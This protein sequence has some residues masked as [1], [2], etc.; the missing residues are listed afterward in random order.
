MCVV[1]VCFDVR[2]V[3]GCF[4]VVV[5]VL[6]CGLVVGDVVFDVVFDVAFDV[7]RFVSWS[8]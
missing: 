8:W 1:S 5:V 4:L 3:V 6:S 7:V 2:V